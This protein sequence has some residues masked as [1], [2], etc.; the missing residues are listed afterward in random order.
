M[1]VLWVA[2]FANNLRSLPVRVGFDDEHHLKYIEYIMLNR[3]LPLAKE[4]WEMFQPPLYYSVSAL[5]LQSLGISAKSEAA[6]VVLRMLGCVAGLTQFAFLFGSIRLLFPDRPRCQWF[7]LIIA[8]LLPTPL[9]LCH[10]VSN[11]MPA[12]ALGSGAIYFTLRILRQD[13]SRLRPYIALGIFL[14]AALLTKFSS[15]VAVPVVLTV[16]AAR[17]IHKRQTGAQTSFLNIGVAAAICLAVCG[18][19][20]VRVWKH[21]GN[22][23]IGNWDPATGFVWWQD[24]GYRTLESFTRTGRALVA[25]FLSG[26]FSVPDGLYSTFWGDGLYGGGSAMAGRPPWNYELMAAGYL[27]SL[28]PMLAILVGFFCSIR[29]LVRQPKAEG[30]LLLGLSFST[31]L[32]LILMTLKIPSYAQAKAFYALPALTPAIAFAAHGLDLQMRPRFMMASSLGVLISKILTLVLCAALGTW[33]MNSF[34][35]FWIRGQ[36]AEAQFLLGGWRMLDNKSSDAITHFRRALRD[37]PNHARATIG[38]STAL[39]NLGEVSEALKLSEQLVREHPD[40]AECQ[41]H[42]ALTLV[43]VNQTDR[44][45][46]HLQRA[47]ELAPDHA[48][49]YFQLGAIFSLSNR[50]A[51]AEAALRQALRVS[52]GNADIHLALAQLLNKENRAKDAI[53]HFRTSLRLKPDNN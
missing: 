38:L 39:V 12:A 44:A 27:L 18:W 50:S 22:P 35:S 48:T 51:E 11:E 15:V 34:A 33:A 29:Q 31:L 41:V 42:L 32:P 21:F 4:G 43:R 30:F 26:L 46:A 25:P 23:F 8:A 14:G 3:S 40:D 6:V 9:Y 5:L 53:D 2:L 13:D 10:F 45:I 16:L 37:D 19:H 20:Y 49:A 47:L 17:S 7:G 52:P 24:P 28:L 1:A 36:S